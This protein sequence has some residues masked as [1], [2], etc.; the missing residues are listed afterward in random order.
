[1][2]PGE[3]AA[4][5]PSALLAAWACALLIVDLFVPVRRRGITAGL[6]AVAIVTA[7]VA[8][9]LLAGRQAVA[10]GS[11]VVADGTG[12]FFQIILLLGG[13]FG[14]AL[15]F[16]YIRRTDIERGEYYILL[17][18]SLS[19]ML[20]LT[21]SSDLVMVFLGL[22]LLSIPL[23]VLAGFALPKAASEE[24]ALKYFLLGAFSSSFIVFGIALTYGATGTT[25]L[26]AVAEQVLAGQAD[27][28]LLVVGALMVLV[29]LAFKVAVV[30]FHMW[31][32]DVYQGA[33]TSVVAF[34]TVGSK[35][36]GFAVLLRVLT[37]AFPGL[38]PYWTQV[39]VWISALTMIWGNVAAVGQTNIK[40][41]LAYSAIAHAG[42]VFMAVPAAAV[43]GL[44]SQAYSAALFYLLAYSLTSLGAWGVVLA[45]E[46]SQGGGT[47]VEDF[48][49]LGSRRPLLAAAMTIF[50][51][52]LTGVPPTFGFIAKFVLF[53]T[54]IE[55]NLIGLAL[56][57]VLTTLVSAYY[58]LRVVVNMYM[59]SGLPEVRAE[60]WLNL[61]I[62]A[63][64]IAVVVFGLLPQPILQVAYRAGLASF[65]P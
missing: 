54:A 28:P 45:V 33:P 23:Y 62:G 42:Y 40:R 15:A 27:L 5:L 43:P 1:M 59:R 8:L 26:Y 7:M 50:M 11:M 37:A 53:Q 52:S 6:T 44:T 25:Q 47:D 13:L 20:L 18:F 39:A 38:S 60:R 21:I 24:S 22:E 19:G 9:G 3:L 55:A 57:G 16:D 58:Y 63:M 17:L 46:H 56:I 65:V 64:A 35:V 4:I 34:M 10:P 61:T 51:L 2:A 49:G 30:P 29:S 12:A 36:A 14:V 32:P 41:M 31:T 48:A